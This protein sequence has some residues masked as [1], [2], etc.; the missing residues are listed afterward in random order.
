M[1]E[2]AVRDGLFP[3]CVTKFFNGK[4]IVHN[5]V[6]G[7]AHQDMLYD[8]ASITKVL[9]SIATLR[10]VAMREI[11]VDTKVS[12]IL[13]FKEKGE[14]QDMT[15]WNTLTYTA[16]FDLPIE[17]MNHGI[18][19]LNDS[20]ELRFFNEAKLRGEPGKR[21]RYGNPHAFVQGKVIE[22]VTG[23]KLPDAL[24]GL[25][26]DPL[27]FTHTT[28][29]PPQDDFK[30]VAPTHRVDGSGWQYGIVQDPMSQKFLPE[31]VGIAGVFSTVTDMSKLVWFLA[32]G[33]AA[34][35]D[36]VLPKWLW[37]AMISDQL[38]GRRFS[39]G[40]HRYGLG[41][42]MPS[43]G[44]VP[45]LSFCRRGVFMSGS[46]GPFIFAHPCWSGG[47]SHPRP[48]G[49]V[50]LCNTRRDIPDAK[51]KGRLFRRTMVQDFLEEM[52]L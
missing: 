51:N 34:N 32:T 36:E 4:E 18:H 3:G 30:M 25:V 39:D 26:F 13:P 17:L 15:V 49:G 20:G 12:S 6:F 48:I 2:N 40:T 52:K 7:E 10:L 1:I 42:D 45:D 11:S 29:E 9:V 21:H 43:E 41:I 44:Y 22:G 47:G 35:F 50:I 14:I 27:G 31:K 38:H 16:D 28:F 8:I 5:K 24:K 23:Q 37:E 33:L 46:S 19:L